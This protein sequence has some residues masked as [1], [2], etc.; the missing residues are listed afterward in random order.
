M[1]KHNKL[2]EIIE[3]EYFKSLPTTPEIDKSFSDYFQEQKKKKNNLK[4]SK[5]SNNKKASLSKN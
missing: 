1:K 5:N 3:I 2:P 4:L